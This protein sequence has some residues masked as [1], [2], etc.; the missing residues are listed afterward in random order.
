MLES[1]QMNASLKS[2]EP[3]KLSH[4]KPRWQ[5]DRFRVGYHVCLCVQKRFYF[6]DFFGGV[7]RGIHNVCKSTHL[8]FS[9]ITCVFLPLCISCVSKLFSLNNIRF[10]DR[11]TILISIVLILI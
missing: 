1:I 4:I 3:A 8:Y 10:F 7:L 11:S 9:K 5:S 2:Y 6:R